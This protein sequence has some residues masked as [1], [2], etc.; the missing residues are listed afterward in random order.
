MQPFGISPRENMIK[1]CGEEA[2]IPR[3]L[4]ERVKSAG[5][6]QFALILR[7]LVPRRTQPI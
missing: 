6:S 1:E 3:E 5:K 4:A 7:H 2:G